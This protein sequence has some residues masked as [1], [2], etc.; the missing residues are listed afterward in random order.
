MKV[1]QCNLNN[2]RAAR[3]IMSQF[4]SEEKIDMCIIS[5]PGRI[6][7]D[8][9]L[10]FLSLDGKAAIYFRGDYAAP[11]LTL[12]RRGRHFVAVKCGEVVLAACYISPNIPVGTYLEALD[13]LEELVRSCGSH[14]VVAGDFNARSPS[15]DSGRSNRRGELL[16]HWA[17]SCDLLLVNEGFVSTCIRPQGES[18]IDL[19]WCSA[20]SIEMIHDW[21]VLRDSETLS[22][23]AYISF[24]IDLSSS[25]RRPVGNNNLNYIRW[26][27]SKFDIDKFKESLSVSLAWGPEEDLTALKLASWI[28]S[29]MTAACDAASPRVRAG[30]SRRSCHWW[31][32]DI[33]R[34]RSECVAARRRLT[35]ARRGNGEDRCSKLEYRV[36]RAKLRDAI[37]IAKAKSWDELVRSVDE[38]PWG[39]P[40]KLVLG[41]LRR[42][43]KGLTETLDPLVRERLLD[44]L[45]PRGEP[46]I[47]DDLDDFTWREE[48]AVSEG[49]VL[50]ALRR[51]SCRNVAPGPDGIKGV[52]WGKVPLEMVSLMSTVFT[53][54]LDEGT[55]PPSWK[56]AR[57]VL[58]PKGGV[59][60]GSLP[61]AR[62]ICLL[63]DIG[64]LFERIIV[65]RLRGWMSED[66][67]R[68]LS[69]GQFGFREGLST[70][71]ALRRVK[72][73]IEETVSSGGAAVAISLD[74]SNAFNSL[75]WP[76]VGDALRNRGVPDYLRRILGSYLSQR[77]VEYSD[78]N[79]V[80]HT[81][82]MTAG[83]PQ[84]SVLGPVLW[85]LCF[86]SIPRVKV[87]RG[88]A[89]ICYAD[90]TLVLGSGRDAE[91][92]VIMANIQVARVCRRIAHLGLKVAA[93]KTEA[94]LF[95]RRHG[96]ARVDVPE[97]R[98]GSTV[99]PLSKSMKYLGVYLDSRLSFRDH[100]SYVELKCGKVI[101]ALSR[102]MP[103]LRGPREKKRKLYANVLYSV[104]LYGAP[105]WYDVALSSRMILQ[106]IARLQRKIN[107]RVVSSYRT[108]SHVAVTLLAGSP[109]LHLV[110]C[111]RGRVFE[112]L[113]D[114]R[115][116]GDLNSDAIEDIRLSEQLLLR[117]QWETF[118]RRNDLPS[119]RLR[120]AILPCFWEWIDRGHGSM[121]FHLTQIFTGHGC[122][123]SFLHRIGKVGSPIC[124][125]CEEY[126]D[127][128][129]HTVAECP[130]W[131]SERADLC[132]IVGNDL[133]LSGLVR[134]IL[135]SREAWSAL[136]LYADKVLTAKEVAERERER[137]G[138]AARYS[139]GDSS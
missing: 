49:E 94:V 92:A 73:F 68:D 3:D 107:S 1:L 69:I 70:C 126:E 79:G 60:A 5:E 17:V 93:E 33:A 30:H 39:L 25:S 86:D 98:I 53:R 112:R 28:E 23:H 40:Y 101:R 18:V 123:N 89:V 64:K 103:N 111:E 109:P 43:S 133:S 10:W 135:R 121:S 58:I 87:E 71:D 124:S 21:G 131:R 56:R 125:H 116:I 38:N 19:T 139:A 80:A 50:A 97:I 65:G 88:C 32:D 26:N 99:V 108:A 76:S 118:L 9:P 90:D 67:R 42:F 63:N 37:K 102:L 4:I 16:E 106:I 35:R 100:F 14:V 84:G 27:T 24:E 74:I 44:S 62:P 78:G 8:S 138:V 136:M 128:A 83:V 104:I 82:P 105:I 119:E 115:R 46:F 59:A 13:E 11:N 85:N 34:L 57:L 113:R 31:N 48:L 36:A 2:S 7:S 81:R 95:N 55:V 130:A 114:L 54:C 20:D 127:T 117:R 52:V 47:L 91:T 45:F 132:L 129:D 72:I 137:L 22:D 75:P 15:W 51:G 61:K 66:P 120:R 77:S 29:T 12:V 41:K 96:R 6:L 134:S 122:F 110:A